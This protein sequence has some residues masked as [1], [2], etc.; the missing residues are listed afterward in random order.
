MRKRS[1]KRRL[2]RDEKRVLD[3]CK[4]PACAEGGIELLKTSFSARALHNAWVFQ[5]ELFTSRRMMKRG[6]YSE[7]ADDIL[8][9]SRYRAALQSSHILS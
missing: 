3:S 2:S 7:Y 9:R 6:V 1:T 8:R 4:C 5:Q